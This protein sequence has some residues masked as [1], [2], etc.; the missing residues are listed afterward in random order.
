M[1]GPV[2]RL[3]SPVGLG[4]A[5][6]AL[7]GLCVLTDVLA[8]FA[9]TNMYG[10]ADKAIGEG[11]GTLS[12][13]EVD[14]A[15]LLQFVSGATQT[16]A[17]LACAVVFLV[18]FHRVRSNA[19]AFRP[20]GHRM[21]RGWSIGGWFVPVVNLWFPKKIANDVWA[22]SLPYQPDG[23]PVRAP[24]TVMNWWW[25]LWIATLVL[26]RA[27]GRMYA[28]ADSFEEIRRATGVLIAAD[29]VDIV[30]A[31][32]AF[33]FVRRLTALQDAKAHQGPVL[34]VAVTP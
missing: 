29:A 13:R 25:G 9:G 24:R 18:W 21:S 3:A 16:A 22:A 15:D 7:L 8:L 19:E 10:V 1:P 23:S 30:A 17:L 20:D 6:A 32:L 28:R 31:V 26:G 33:L 12:D 34:P 2:P 27:G 4:R 5:V 11:V 14:R